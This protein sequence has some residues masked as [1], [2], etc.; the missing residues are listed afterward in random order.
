MIHQKMPKPKI[1]A[2]TT[3]WEIPQEKME[4]YNGPEFVANIWK[5][6]GAPVP[7]EAN[8]P[9]FV[10]FTSGTTGKPKGVSH[11]HAYN[12]G[13]V[14]TMKVSFNAIPGQDRMLTIGALGWITGQSYQIS[15][16]LAA[17]ITAV[18]MRGPPTRPSRARFAQE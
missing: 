12:A 17:R 6:Y 10:I 1:E 9:L 5:K 11:V 2:A 13:L 8:T 4:P 15:A 7:C 18:I 14:E 16:V 3:M